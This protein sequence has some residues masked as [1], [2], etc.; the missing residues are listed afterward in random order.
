MC[1][2]FPVFTRCFLK[3]PM[4]E[5][6]STTHYVEK[7]KKGNNAQAKKQNTGMCSDGLE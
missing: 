7:K 1:F 4:C 5:N 3:P 6:G 2:Y